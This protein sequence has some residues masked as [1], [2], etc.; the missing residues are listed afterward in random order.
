[1]SKEVVKQIQLLTKEKKPTKNYKEFIRKS[2]LPCLAGHAMDFVEACCLLK[3]TGFRCHCCF[4]I[5]ITPES[6]KNDSKIKQRAHL[7]LSP[8]ISAHPCHLCE[9]AGDGVGGSHTAGKAHLSSLAIAAH[10]RYICSASG[11]V[12]ILEAFKN[13]FKCNFGPS[14]KKPLC[15]PGWMVV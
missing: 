13:I 11:L 6:S 15:F 8:L 7:S 14:W 12:K 3:N 4:F 10:R 5:F 1:M 9:A 2:S